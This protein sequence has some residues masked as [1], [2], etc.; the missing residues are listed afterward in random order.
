MSP[1]THLE[2]ARSCH[3]NWGPTDWRR[4]EDLRAGEILEAARRMQQILEMES[5]EMPQLYW[6]EA[7]YQDLPSQRKS[8]DIY[9]NFGGRLGHGR[10]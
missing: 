5:A 3:S 7:I 2:V 1:P 8:M 9:G 6:K 10:F 4:V